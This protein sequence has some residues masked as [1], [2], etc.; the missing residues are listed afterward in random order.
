MNDL[1]TRSA[2]RIEIGG[3]THLEWASR[4]LGGVNWP[5]DSRCIVI[6]GGENVRAV[7][8]YN[9]WMEHSCCIHIATDGRRNWATRGT[10]YG[11]FALPFLANNLRRVT[12]PIAERN[13][14]AQILVLKLGFKFEGR[15]LNALS[16]DNEV[17]FGM[18]RENCI[19][20][21]EN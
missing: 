7:V 21:K 8:V 17:L 9:M 13:V 3:P 16:N 18:L 10:L 20:I 19:W 15:L 11:I 14:D 2:L 5:S 4:V 1:N 12:V 6:M